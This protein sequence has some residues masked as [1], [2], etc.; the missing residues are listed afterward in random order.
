MHL[1]RT[2]LILGLLV[3]SVARADDKSDKAEA[4]RH[5]E[6]GKR[7]Y[8]LNEWDEAIAEFKTAYRLFPDPVNLYNIAQAYRLKKGH[9]ADAA[10]FY[11]NYQRE[12]KNKKLRDSVTKVRKDMEACAKTEK[13]A[14]PEEPPPP[15]P[16]PAPAPVMPQPP[17]PAPAPIVAGAPRA[18]VGENAMRPLQVPDPDPNRNRRILSYVLLGS[19]A[20]LIVAGVGESFKKSDLDNQLAQCDEF[21]CPGDEDPDVLQ[22]KRDRASIKANGAFAIGVSAII[23]GSVVFVISRKP[24]QDKRV[25]VVPTRGGAAVSWSF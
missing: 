20:F 14:P 8:N 9:C 15:D 1:G 24:K 18:P 7:R 3:S 6:L 22:D 11:A 19:G 5:Y 16:A 23:V 25:T 21:G 2:L 4:T 13:P 10:Q 12:E 17:P